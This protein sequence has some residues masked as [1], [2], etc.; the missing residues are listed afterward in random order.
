MGR[1]PWPLSLAARRPAQR[2]RARPRVRPRAVARRGSPSPGRAARAASSARGRGHLHPPAVRPGV[3]PWSRLFALPPRPLSSIV[4]DLGYT[5]PYNGPRTPRLPRYASRLTHRAA[6]TN[7]ADIHGGLF[8]RTS[9]LKACTAGYLPSNTLAL[10]PLGSR[11]TTSRRPPL[12]RSNPANTRSNV[13][14][15]TS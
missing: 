9:A 5:I 8:S 10:D 1:H 15:S 2:A 6:N 4:Y 7:R 13:V 12:I 11:T 14:G 3:R